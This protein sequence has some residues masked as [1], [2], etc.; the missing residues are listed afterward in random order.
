M[1]RYHRL[2][3]YNHRKRIIALL[4]TTSASLLLLFIFA[5]MGFYLTFCMAEISEM[6]V[7]EDGDKEAAFES[8]GICGWYTDGF[9]NVLL[10]D[11][12]KQYLSLMFFLTIAIELVPLLAF[13][14]LDQPHDCFV[15]L[16]KD[17]DRIYSSL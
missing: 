12:S 8:D 11:N 15:C 10:S 6:H 1:Y 3:F 16:G 7:G 13:F 5:V 4:F 17:P 14:A 9:E 2:E